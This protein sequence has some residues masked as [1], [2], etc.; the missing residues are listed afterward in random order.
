MQHR[1][2]LLRFWPRRG[3]QSGNLPIYLGSRRAGDLARMLAPPLFLFARTG[4]IVGGLLD[5]P[6]GDEPDGPPD[7][8]SSSYLKRRGKPITRPR[9]A[10]G[11]LWRSGHW[12]ASALSRVDGQDLTA[13]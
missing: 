9:P 8:T 3:M 10:L 5:P 12:E 1:P 11:Q 13:M 2:G 4:A 6:A 7:S